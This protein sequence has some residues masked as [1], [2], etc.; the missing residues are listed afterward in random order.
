MLVSRGEE[1]DALPPGALDGIE[2]Y[3][4]D[5]LASLSFDDVDDAPMGAVLSNLHAKIFVAERA[6]RAHVLVGSANATDA[7]I[8]GNVEFLCELVGQPS[9]LGVAAFMGKD[10]PF[11]AMLKRYTPLD[12]PIVDAAADASRALEELLFDLAQVGFRIEVAKVSDGWA[13]HVTSDGA[14]EI[15]HGVR[16]TLAPQNR[17]PEASSLAPGAVVEIELAPREAAD[18][19]PFL[20]LTA[21]SGSGGQVLERATI[22]CAQLVGAPADRIEDIVVRRQGSVASSPCRGRGAGRRA[23]PWRAGSR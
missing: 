20:R 13:A 16:V 18:I 4:L 17:T 7:G 14:L 11:L 2:A 21:R 9:A 8:A 5:P 1:L 22:V 19:T 23:P 6:R 10:A 3:E 12:A 15:P